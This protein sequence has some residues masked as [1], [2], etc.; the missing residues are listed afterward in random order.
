MAITWSRA[1]RVVRLF[2][3]GEMKLAG[4]VARYLNI[5]FKNSGH[6]V[7]DIGLKRDNGITA[8]AYFSDLMVY[9]REFQFSH[10]NNVNEIK[11]RLFLNH[12]LHKD[13]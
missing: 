7:Y 6:A 13:I 9:S 11:N 5:N 8:H 10:L 4:T 3:N 2:V 12:P 1:A